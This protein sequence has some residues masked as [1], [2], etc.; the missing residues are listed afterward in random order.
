M[1]SRDVW[2]DINVHR[3]RSKSK[4]QSQ[5]NSPEGEHR[6][7]G[8]IPLEVGE[9]PHEHDAIELST[10]PSRTLA[11]KISNNTVTSHTPQPPTT[12]KIPPLLALLKRFPTPTT[13]L[14]RLPYPLLPFA[15]AMFILVQGLASTGWIKVFAKWWGAWARASGL[16]GVVGGMGF[17]SVCLCNVCGTNIGATILLARVIQAWQAEDKPSARS[18]H[19]AIYALAI[20]S[21]YGA[22]STVFSASLA[23]LL[24][25]DILRQKG[26]IVKRSEFAKFNI[27][28]IFSAMTVGCAVLVAQIYV[29]PPS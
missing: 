16:L 19:G 14:S 27:A 18:R 24:W 8:P 26:I 28:L 25:R 1:F 13:T 15:F 11:R 4:S 3:R 2:H 5:P 23:G 21:N 29:H 9:T 22:F 7:G 6:S 10:F 17:V 12:E 20:G